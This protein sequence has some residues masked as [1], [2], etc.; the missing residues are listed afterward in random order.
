MVERWKE[1]WTTLS[2]HQRSLMLAARFVSANKAGT[3]GIRTT[4]L[5]FRVWLDDVRGY[6]RV[7]SSVWTEELRSKRLAKMGH[8]CRSCC[9]LEAH[10]ETSNAWL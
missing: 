3:S 10:E 5:S 2:L 1:L 6:E 7:A 8:G 4:T 9:G